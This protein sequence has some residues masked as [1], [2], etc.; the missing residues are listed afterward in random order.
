MPSSTYELFVQAMADRKQILCTYD[1]YPRELCPIILGH[2]QGQEKPLTYQFGG[3]SESGLPLRGDWKCL[4]LAK[5]SNVPLRDGTWH[6]A[7]AT[8]S[9]NAASKSSIST[10]TRHAPT[11]QNAACDPDA[12][13][14]SRLSP[15]SP[16]ALT[17][18]LRLYSISAK[19]TVR[20]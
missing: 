15:I 4:F 10:S 2:S 20:T 8:P 19:M 5:V 18:W 6:A 16:A 17:G 12:D 1:G 9:A 7:T 14:L 3:E 11:T 13:V